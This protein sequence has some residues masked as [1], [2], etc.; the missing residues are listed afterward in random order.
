MKASATH[1]RPAE[2]ASAPTARRANETELVYGAVA[3]SIIIAL[4]PALFFSFGFHNDY[5]QWSY[6]SHTC[7]TQYPETMTLIYVGRYFGAL[8]QNLQ[9]FTIHTL[10]DLWRWRLIGILSTAGLASYYLYI[11]S[12]RRT[13]TWQNAL[14]SVAVFTLP[15]MQ[16]QAIWVAMYAFWTPPM[17]LSLAA[18]H[19]LLKATDRDVFADHSAIW[20]CTQLTLLA[21]ASVL[22]GCFFYPLSATVVLLPAAHLLL[23]ENKLQFR[24]M[25][26]LA[27]VVLGCAF[28]ALFVIHKFIV[29][30]HLSNVPYL[31]EADRNYGY[32]F[33]GNLLAEASKR[34]DF[35]LWD[36]AY[37][38]LVLE[39][40][41]FPKLVSVVSVV[42]A[43]YCV[44]RIHRRS[45]SA[46]ELLNVLM[47]CGLFLVALAPLLI[48]SQFT[49]AYRV[50]F[51]TNGF[52]L[53]MLFWLL[54][55]LPIGSLRLASIF[56]A[57]GTGC[58]F[59]DVYGASA[60]A[61]AEY[62]LYSKSL[63][64]LSPHDFHSIA[65]LRPSWRARQAFDF[66][67]NAAE[68]AMFDLLI[69]PRYK[70][71]ATFDVTYMLLP[72][73]L[74]AVEANVDTVPLAL[75]ENAMAIDTS[76]MYGVPSFKDAVSQLAIVSARPRD[77][78]GGYRF[79]PAN[80]VDGIPSTFW[81][82]AGVPFPIEL[83][84]DFPKAHTLAGY[85]LSTVEAP[86]RMP[87][88]W[89]IWV[90]PDQRHWRRLQ[91][92]TECQPWKNDET[93]HY[94]VEAAPDITGIKLVVTKTD[95]GSILRIYEFRPE[96]NVPRSP[97]WEAAVA[98]DASR[99]KPETC[100]KV[101]LAARAAPELLYAYK[102]YDVIRAGELYVG[103]AQDVGPI[104]VDAVLANIAPRPPD[105][106]FIIADDSSSLKAKIDVYAKEA[107]AKALPESLY[108][109]RGYDAIRSGEVYFGVAKEPSPMDVRGVLT[110]AV[111]PPRS[112]NFLIA[113]SRQYST[114][115]L[116]DFGR[117]P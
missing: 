41:L 75:E 29:L 17:L 78:R 90:S 58:S 62:A 28:V 26:V 73:T 60:A 81:E 117:K 22:A 5:N 14:L 110:N 106:K 34:L 4:S 69:G 55:Q 47:T 104:D 11:V 98:R 65:I 61:H 89:E 86:E 6:D 99:L 10:D 53:L 74:P 32:N 105:D 114:T 40:P 111:R 100:A 33:A 113:N 16:F 2:A 3:G 48:V 35:Y 7:C 109:Y 50:R 30:P 13:P 24:Q 51:A 66:G 38:W 84:L 116:T 42:A 15:T 70:G 83:E 56:A 91:Q 102:D 87:S 54:R 8:A 37:L 80:A 36:G 39:I 103:V 59:V 21:S 9:S 97:A 23:S 82:I 49:A 52:E 46:G 85:S 1:A 19:L 79:G 45:I 93:R 31:G 112:E 72:P 88:S 44:I 76:S 95:D 94:N 20:R 12:L 108:A 43:A 67:A 64:N 25:A 57:L 115:Y 107:K 68:P 63:A 71:E 27:A 77:P 92:I 18:A 96:F 101:A